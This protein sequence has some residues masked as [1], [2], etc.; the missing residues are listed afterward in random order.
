MG[1]ESGFIGGRDIQFIDTGPEQGSQGTTHEK[2][3]FLSPFET[4]DAWTLIDAFWET[5]GAY[6]ASHTPNK[7]RLWTLDRPPATGHRHSFY[8]RSRGQPHVDSTK[9]DYLPHD[10]SLHDVL[11]LL[12]DQ[13]IVRLTP[14]SLSHAL[15]RRVID[16]SIQTLFTSDYAVT[17]RGL[18]AH[19]FEVWDHE[20]AGGDA[21]FTGPGGFGA[22]AASLSA[23]LDVRYHQEV[24]MFVCSIPRSSSQLVCSHVTIFYF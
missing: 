13:A 4:A 8:T 3:R 14:P 9:A 20:Y 24:I 22:L 12:Q 17:P 18:S 16:W 15:A 7:H 1:G 5:V 23:P 19:W 6:L 11:V 21:I 2:G 10:A